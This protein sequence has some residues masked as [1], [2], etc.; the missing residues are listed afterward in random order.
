MYK[1]IDDTGKP[2]GGKADN[3]IKLDDYHLTPDFVIIPNEVL[4]SVF[5]VSPIREFPAEIIDNILEFLGSGPLI[6]RSSY[7]GEDSTDASYAGI[8]L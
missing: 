3:L 7:C 5:G 4:E 8:F 2:L 6:T 1:I